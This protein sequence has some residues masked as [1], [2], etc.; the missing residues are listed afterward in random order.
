[1]IFRPAE[2]GSQLVL[3]SLLA[4][5]VA[6]SHPVRLFN[7][8]SRSN[9]FSLVPNWRFFAP[10]PVTLD[11]HVIVR[12]LRH[13]ESPT[14]WRG[15]EFIVERNAGQ[16]VWYP[17]GRRKK[18]LL[19]I[20]AELGSV[21][22]EGAHSVHRSTAY[23]LL[24]EH[25]RDGIPASDRAEFDSFQFAVVRTGGYQADVEPDVQVISPPIAL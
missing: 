20:C 21:M 19:D 2:A 11:P 16:F 5:T 9:Q 14:E 10:E 25:V 1:M 3:A 12:L 17:E 7:R 24:L 13:G 4:A 18:A 22:N 15:V 23:R 8:I 6:I